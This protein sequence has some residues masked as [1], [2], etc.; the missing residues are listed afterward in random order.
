M[1]VVTAGGAVFKSDGEVVVGGAGA[2]AGGGGGRAAEADTD[3]P[4]W[5]VEHKACYV[6]IYS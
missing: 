1:S 3:R 4:Y 2:R 6:H 5:W